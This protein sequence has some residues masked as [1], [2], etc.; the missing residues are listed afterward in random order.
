MK[1]KKD[2]SKSLKPKLVCYSISYKTTLKEYGHN[3]ILILLR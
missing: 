3:I 1:K 2:K